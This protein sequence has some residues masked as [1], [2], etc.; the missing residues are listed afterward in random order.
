MG[1]SGDGEMGRSGD[2]EMGRSGDG[3]MGRS[4]DREIGRSGRGEPRPVRGRVKSGSGRLHVSARLTQFYFALC[5]SQSVANK[6][7]IWQALR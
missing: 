4:G 2:G 5:P 3:E 1:R 6:R 7:A